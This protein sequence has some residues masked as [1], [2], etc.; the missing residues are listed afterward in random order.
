MNEEEQKKQVDT[1]KEFY[2]KLEKV[3]ALTNEHLEGFLQ[4]EDFTARDILND[5][6][7]N[8]TTNED[9]KNDFRIIHQKIKEAHLL[10]ADL[11]YKFIT[12]D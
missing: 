1:Q 6:M 8:G 10:M 9:I 2:Q 4:E 12:Y 11:L 5:L 7:L 3:C